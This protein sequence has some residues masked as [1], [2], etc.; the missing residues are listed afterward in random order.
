M[1]YKLDKT[2]FCKQL[3]HKLKKIREKEE[4]SVNEL[5]QKSG[6]SNSTIYK[7]EC[8]EINTRTSTIIKLARALE[9]KV[10]EIFDF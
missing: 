4:L 9:Y 10:S 1:R 2:K 8:G 6:V 3:G 7:I 5:A